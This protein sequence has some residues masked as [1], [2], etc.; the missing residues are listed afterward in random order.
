MHMWVCESL[1]ART[2]LKEETN[3]IIRKYVH[4]RKAAKAGGQRVSQTQRD[5][6]DDD[7][8]DDEPN[9]TPTLLPRK[10]K[11]FVISSY[12]FYFLS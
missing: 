6:A 9:A 10:N 11:V 7:D 2:E 1:S 12:Y 5:D 4:I 3:K 8:D